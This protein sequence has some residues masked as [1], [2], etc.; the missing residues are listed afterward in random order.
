MK[1][2]GKIPQKRKKELDYFCLQSTPVFIC[3][4]YN[5]FTY[6]HIFSI[7]IALLFL[8]LLLA[9]LYFSSFSFLIFSPP[10]RAARVQLLL[11]TF[12][13][14][15]E[16]L[17]VGRFSLA[18]NV[19]K[20]Q[21]KGCVFAEKGWPSE[22]RG[23]VCALS[24]GQKH[25]SRFAKNSSKNSRNENVERRQ[26]RFIIFTRNKFVSPLFSHFLAHCFCSSETWR[27]FD[28]NEM[29]SFQRFLFCL[30]VVARRIYFSKK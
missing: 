1:K 23:V 25:P 15:H 8:V 5:N 18:M 3:V 4:H 10:F 24:R 20:A 29:K 7:R 28:Q 13:L 22:G 17:R 6:K 30:N 9:L 14:R 16:K 21:Q 12:L 2:M 26:I 27:K 19:L 11:F